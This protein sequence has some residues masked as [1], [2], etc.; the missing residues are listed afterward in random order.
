MGVKWTQSNHRN[1]S[2]S[3]RASVALLDEFVGLKS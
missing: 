2:V 1:I 3:H